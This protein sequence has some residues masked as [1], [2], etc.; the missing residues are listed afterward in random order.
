MIVDCSILIK[1]LKVYLPNFYSHLEHV[2]YEI[3]LSNIIYKWFISL[4]IQNI[5]LEMN[6]LIWDFLFLD[7]NI[8]LFKS[9][10]VIF[11]M[12]KKKIMKCKEF[13]VINSI[14]EESTNELRDTNTMIYY[15]ILHKFSFDNYFIETNRILLESQIIQTINNDNKV[16]MSR[17]ENDTKLKRKASYAKSCLNCFIDWPLCI[18]DLSYKYNIV[19][20]L[21]LRIYD[22]T[23]FVENYFFDFDND[24]HNSKI[25]RKSLK[26]VDEESKSNNSEYELEL[27]NYK[28]LLIERRKHICDEDKMTIK[29]VYIDDTCTLFEQKEIDNSYVE[30]K[31][32][33][34]KDFRRKKTDSFKEFVEFSLPQRNDDS[35]YKLVKSF[36]FGRIFLI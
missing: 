25:G 7:R 12:L 14:F 30:I 36:K 33:T 22:A 2:G 27:E 28:N 16:K 31:S 19:N 21:C 34:V 6:M 3:T 4:F 35:V 26:I 10:I 18:Y 17:I 23:I 15:L 29:S 5:S 9:A 8:V 13:E 24:S 1:L 32:N 20:H 11:K